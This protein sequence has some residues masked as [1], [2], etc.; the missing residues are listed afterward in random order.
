MRTKTQSIILCV[1]A[2]TLASPIMLQTGAHSVAQDYQWDGEIAA[3]EAVQLQ[4]VFSGLSG[5]VFVTHAHDGTNRLFV[6]EQIGRIRVAQPGASTT[7]V[8]LDI[9]SR[10]LSGGETRFVRR[11]FSPPVLD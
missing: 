3:P 4:L 9:V 2:L 5:T 11:G 7:T 10:V 8:F 1:A 6:I